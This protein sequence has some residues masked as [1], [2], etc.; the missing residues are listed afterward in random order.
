MARSSECVSPGTIELAQFV[1]RVA[2]QSA[3]TR[4][5]QHQYVGSVSCPASKTTARWCFMYLA[6][7]CDPFGMDE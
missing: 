5:A 1:V 2:F 7:L 4:L 6:I 3:I